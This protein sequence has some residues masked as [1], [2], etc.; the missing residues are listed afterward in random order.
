MNL[1]KDNNISE[2]IKRKK[3]QF[4]LL[5]AVTA[6]LI[7]ILIVL[8]VL[9]GFLGDKVNLKIDITSNGVL[10]FSDETISTL[11]NLDSEVNMYS[12]VPEDDTSYEIETIRE[13]IEKYAK[14]SGK[15]KYTVIDAN[16]NP[17]F[18]NKYIAL[19]ETLGQYTVIFETENKYKT[20][21]LN[22]AFIYNSQ[23]QSVTGIKA[24]QLFTSAL[25]YVTNEN[26]TKIGVVSGHGEAGDA[27]YFSELLK[28]EG[29]MAVDVNLLSGDVPEDVNMLV[30]TTP[31][32][33]YTTEE[34]T[35]LD[36]F[37]DAGNSVQVFF[38]I[39]GNNL[40]NLTAYLSEWGVE[41]TKGFIIENDAGNYYQ[42]PIFVLPEVL[43]SKATELIAQN[44]LR[45]LAPSMMPIN[46]CKNTS[47]TETPL[48]KT[49]KTSICKMNL[50][51]QTIE[52]EDGDIEG[53]QIIAALYEREAN[54]SKRAKL[55]V[56]GGSAIIAY[57]IM[58]SA[59]AN[60]DFYF[61]IISNMSG[62]ENSIYIRAKDITSSNIV[63]P[64]LTGIIYAG[65]TVIIIPLAL[66]IAGIVIW[67][68]R[69]HL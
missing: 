69:R 15:I 63:M 50:Q 32:T 26:D 38:D 68:K 42:S 25:M 13:I 17:A 24:E 65:V 12:L 52:K 55:F 37:L 62:N 58:N 5:K 1:F 29:Y 61:N 2:T 53:E 51:T 49:S 3:G 27:S 59:F 34:I 60:K 16:K 10:K 9:F 45:V 40:D 30:I 47:V 6:F 18:L 31:Q 56:S 7:V 66:I 33:D 20:V 19:G 23:T 4:A 21:D 11:K 64:A 67:I 28:G 41:F 39:T 44:N 48:L 43:Q 54:D 8:N 46:P 57:D 22:E 36:E 35:K 14:L